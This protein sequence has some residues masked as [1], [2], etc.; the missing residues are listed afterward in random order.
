MKQKVMYSYLGVNGVIISPILL[1]GIQSV[2][3]IRLE[4]DEG[5]VLTKDGKNFV[6]TTIVPNEEE[7]AL[8]REVKDKSI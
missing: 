4:A 1:D 8:W 6:Y 2:K 5:K 3:S 7:A